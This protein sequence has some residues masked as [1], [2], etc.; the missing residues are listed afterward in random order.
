VAIAHQGANGAN[1]T[2][3]TIS[4]PNVNNVTHAGRILI[5]EITWKGTASAT[6]SLPAGWFLIDGLADGDLAFNI[7]A[8]HKP[9][10]PT[11]TDFTLGLSASVPWRVRQHI[12]SGQILDTQD[13][14]L[15]FAAH[16]IA[17]E[18]GTDTTIATPTVSASSSGTD[19]RLSG[20]TFVEDAGAT[21][22]SPADTART[23]DDAPAGQ[24]SLYFYD[25]NGPIAASSS[26]TVTAT[27]NSISQKVAWIGLLR[28]RQ[29]PGIGSDTMGLTDSVIITETKVPVDTENL[30]D[31][32]TFSQ[33]KVRQDNENLTDTIRKSQTLF[34]RDNAGGS[35][36]TVFSILEQYIDSAG[37]TEVFGIRQEK[38]HRDTLGLSDSVAPA[39]GPY[40]PF[41]DLIGITDRVQF[42]VYR[43]ITPTDQV[44]YQLEMAQEYFLYDGVS[45]VW[46]GTTMT[47]HRAPSY[48][49]HDAAVFVFY[50]GYN[51]YTR[52]QTLVDAWVAAGFEVV[53]EVPPDNTQLVSG[54]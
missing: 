9:I 24:S 5:V 37:I 40:V 14:A 30:T 12:Y 33:T 25:S 54:E 48:E 31:T 52:S 13:L 26:N 8:R 43:L 7:I 10:T 46:D 49:V 45:V 35:D 4:V 2:S 17:A 32:R 36:G 21:S 23:L 18:A 53:M 15:L 22:I 34:F 39:T 28:A 42:P 3:N 27:T 29:D 20:F 6:G 19:W 11:N 44:N 16:G 51:W 50:G 1:A 41:Q 38:T 47:A